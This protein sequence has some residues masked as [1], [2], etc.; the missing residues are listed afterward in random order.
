[1]DDQDSGDMVEEKPCILSL[2]AAIETYSSVKRRE[3]YQLMEATE[4]LE[5]LQQRK[6]TDAIEFTACTILSS[7][8]IFYLIC[9]QRNRLMTH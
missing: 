1:M 5:M 9:I 7:E 2:S 6:L 8:L 3:E 4:E